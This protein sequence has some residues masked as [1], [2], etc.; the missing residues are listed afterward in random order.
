[1]SIEGGLFFALCRRAGDLVP[2]DG[3]SP[4]ATGVMSTGAWCS[5]GQAT[6]STDRLWLAGV[7]RDQAL[8]LI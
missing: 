4:W 3:S 8:Q 2:G 1:M 7:P 6:R 5:G